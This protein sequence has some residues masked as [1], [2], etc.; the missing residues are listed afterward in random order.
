MNRVD[1][2]LDASGSRLKKIQ[3]GTLLEVA[4]YFS[5][6]ARSQVVNLKQELEKQ[7]GN[8]FT[9]WCY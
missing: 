6:L 1:D 2:M 9:L 5:V 8:E 7:F 4:D 3:I